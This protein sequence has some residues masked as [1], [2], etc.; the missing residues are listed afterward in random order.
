MSREAPIVRTDS[1]WG[2]ELQIY[3][4]EQMLYR[5]AAM[6]NS[7]TRTGP[8][9]GQVLLPPELQEAKRQMLAQQEQT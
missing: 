9:F 3:V 1:V 5:M 7:L 4:T 2:T 6:I 8:I